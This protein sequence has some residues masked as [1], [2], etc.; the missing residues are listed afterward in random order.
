[1]EQSNS[2]PTPD[3]EQIVARYAD[4]GRRIVAWTS[5]LLA[6]A[7]VMVIALVAGT[8]LV[9]YWVPEESTA[10]T[11]GFELADAW[12]VF[13]ACSLEF[14]AAPFEL[15]REHATGGEDVVIRML[16]DRCRRVLEN[17]TLPAR[18]IGPQEQKLIE[19][20]TQLTPIEQQS[21]KWRIFRSQKF[22]GEGDL[23][24]QELSSQLPLV[25]GIRDDCPDQSAESGM[26]SRLVV[27]GIA[28]AG[29]D[30]TWTTYVGNAATK[31]N[32]AHRQQNWIPRFSKRTLAISDQKGGALV[33]FVGGD[34]TE[35]IG[36]Y[37]DLA[38]QNGWTLASPWQE[39]NEGW[40]ARFT[41]GPDSSFAGIQVQLHVNHN[42]AMQGILLVQ[43]K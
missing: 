27:W 32:S 38:N 34:V 2:K 41:A 1:M 3:P 11:S 43:S 25:L 29:D 12:P 26:T 31:S 33:G 24:A 5:N 16:Q 9:S 15:V 39:S 40:L 30:E 28:L 10:E 36:F 7:V 22:P 19:T 23:E 20:S 8:Q 18:A 42:Q 14:G 13:D 37:N 21:G 17:N 35:A 6:T 4:L